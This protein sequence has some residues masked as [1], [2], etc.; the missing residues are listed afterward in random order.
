MPDPA[1]PLGPPS[2]TVPV[3]TLEVERRPDQVALVRCHGR[4]VAGATDILFSE[5]G[6]LFADYRRVVLDLSDLKHT[7]SMGLGALVR[8][9]VAAMSAGSSLELVNLSQQIRALL[10]LTHLLDVFTVI[11]EN[12][13]KMM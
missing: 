5:V 7:D 13:V 6:P 11:G 2:S 12:R 10:G 1:V 4:L 9:C 8:L 3:L